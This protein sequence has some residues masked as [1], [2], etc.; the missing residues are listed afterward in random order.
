MAER[1]DANLGAG[2]SN[3]WW[4]LNRSLSAYAIGTKMK[5]AA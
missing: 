5:D 2:G 4:G 3:D 1:N